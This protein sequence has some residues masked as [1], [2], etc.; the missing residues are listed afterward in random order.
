[1]TY[2]V[3]AVRDIAAPAPK[4]WGMVADLPRMGE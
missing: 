1:M 2:D 4:V 3:S